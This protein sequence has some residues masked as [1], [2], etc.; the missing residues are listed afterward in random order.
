M[1]LFKVHYEIGTYEGDVHVNASDEEEAIAKAKSRLRM[2]TAMPMA[3][4][5]FTASEETGDDISEATLCSFIHGV[6]NESFSKDE[7]LNEHLEALLELGFIRVEYEDGGYA[8]VIGIADDGTEVSLGSLGQKI[9]EKALKSYLL[10]HPTPRHMVNKMKMTL[11]EFRKLVRNVISE[12]YYGHVEGTIFLPTDSA[13]ALWKGEILG[14]MS[15]GMWENA[16]PFDHWKFWNDLKVE[17]GAPH[18][19]SDSRP[20][21]NSYNL[22]AL[23][24]ILGDRMVKIGRLGSVGFVGTGSDYTG[25]Y[26]PATYEDF[27]ARRGV[28]EYAMKYL[29]KVTPKIAQAYYASKYDD[30]DMRNDLR[31]IKA[32]LKSARTWRDE[33]RSLV[34]YGTMSGERE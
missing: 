13:I 33:E 30:K 18:V 7:E 4:Q 28:P 1:P 16:R 29:D 31:S 32:A 14:Q 6:I 20:E 3:R 5:R 27:E 21:K 23:I 24:P 25:E 19:E 12:G 15:D 11:K 34:R 2:H 9:N 22:A 8:E 26:M 10:A 17:K